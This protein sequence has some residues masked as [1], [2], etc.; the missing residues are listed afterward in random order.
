VAKG[1]PSFPDGEWQRLVEPWGQKPTKKKKK[2]RKSNNPYI[3]ACCFRGFQE[4]SSSLLQKQ[5]PAYSVFLGSY[6]YM[7]Q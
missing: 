4:K 2:K 1:S 5:T 3:P 7:K 6:I